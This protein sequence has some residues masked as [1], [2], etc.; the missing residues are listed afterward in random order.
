F[1]QGLVSAQ[2]LLLT[3]L[4]GPAMIWVARELEAG[5]SPRTRDA[6]RAAFRAT[7]RTALTQ[8]MVVGA[9]ALLTLTIIGI[10]VAVYYGVRWIFS[11]Q[12][13]ILDNTRGREAMRLS[14]EAVK[15]HWMKTALSLPTFAFVGAALAPVIGIILM[16]VFDLN[17]DV[18]NGIGSLIYLLTQPLAYIGLTVMYLAG[19]K[20]TP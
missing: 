13:V 5:R 9:V 10:P 14:S 16:I 11:S 8:L 4:V 17:L 2:A 15:G 18:A 7:G 12:A 20:G 6:F 19:R 1:V 3:L